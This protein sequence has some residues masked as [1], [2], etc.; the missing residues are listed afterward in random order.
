MSDGIKLNIDI[1][2]LSSYLGSEE[3]RGLCCTMPFRHSLN[4]M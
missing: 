3:F 1:V 4:Y 2:G